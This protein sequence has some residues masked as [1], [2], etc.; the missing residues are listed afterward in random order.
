MLRHRGHRLLLE[1]GD[2]SRETGHLGGVR[3]LGGAVYGPVRENA[4][5]QR[6]P[7]AIETTLNAARAE[8]MR[9]QQSPPQL[10]QRPTALAN[11]E[12]EDSASTVI[13]NGSQ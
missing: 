9:A 4:I 13:I 1:R 8:V 6:C 3:A 7:D 11:A 10:A 2:P 12:E 5:Y